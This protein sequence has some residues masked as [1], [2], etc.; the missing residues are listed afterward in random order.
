MLI[1]VE[2][3]NENNFIVLFWWLSCAALEK[4]LSVLGPEARD[5]TD[6]LEAGERG[7]GAA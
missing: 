7:C 4:Q 6:Q 3:A 5:A 2:G 1:R